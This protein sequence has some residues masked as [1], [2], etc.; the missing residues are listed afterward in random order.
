MF[1]WLKEITGVSIQ[2]SNYELISGLSTEFDHH[3]SYMDMI[4]LVFKYYIIQSLYVKDTEK[5]IAVG[6]FQDKLE[7]IS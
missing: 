2:F 7:G 4:I 5:M 1:A 6:I 3:I